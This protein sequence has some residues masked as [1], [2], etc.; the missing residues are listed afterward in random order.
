MHAK[1][2][3]A[4]AALVVGVDVDGLANEDG[5]DGGHED[6]SRERRALG[7]QMVWCGKAADGWLV[8]GGGALRHSV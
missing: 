2:H 7:R 5:H 8:N 1:F 6:A 4:M 3:M